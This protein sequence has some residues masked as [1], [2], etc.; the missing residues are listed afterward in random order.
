MTYMLSGALSAAGGLFY[1]ARQERAD[2]ATGLGWEVQALPTLRPTDI[3]VMDNLGSHKSKAVRRDIR[4][5][6]A[7]LFLLPK[8]SPDLNPIEMLFAKLKHWL[9]QAAGRALGFR[10][11]CAEADPRSRHISRMPKLLRSGRLCFNL[12]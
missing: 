2:S 8:Y 12:N 7:K 3:V 11:R 6:G 10:L 4:T 9:R 1:A 5:T